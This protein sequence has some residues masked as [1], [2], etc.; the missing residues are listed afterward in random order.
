[1]EN[2]YTSLKF[3]AKVKPIKPINNEFTLVKVYIQSVGKNRNFTDMSK[4]SINKYLPT[5]NYCPV[6]GHIRE[7]TDE[8]GILH[9]Y[10]GGHDSE[11]D[12]DKLEYRDLT[13][14]YGVV[15]ENSFDYEMVNEYD[16]DVEYLVGNAI[17]WT[18]RYSELKECIYSND[19]WFNQS[20]ELSIDQYKPYNEDSN[21]TELL[22]WTYS[23]L[24]LL[25]KADEN[26]TNGHTDK[27]IEHTEPCFI[28]SCV[29][30]IE[31]SKTEFSE[32]MNEMKEKL[33]F[34][35]K[36]HSS[37]TEVDYKNETGG[38]SMTTEFENEVV[39]EEVPET[40]TV[41]EENT[42]EK[43][44]E[45][46]EETTKEEVVEEN[47]ETPQSEESEVKEPIDYSVLY[48]ELKTKYDELNEEYSAYKAEHSFLDSDY[49][50]LKT[51]K[52]T[53][54]KEKREAD[55]AS[56]FAE[57]ENEIGE[58]PEFAELKGKA[59]EFSIDA[60]KK[61]CLCIV[62]LYA[63]ANK[64]PETKDVEQKEIKF[65]IESTAI[66]AEDEPYGGLMKKYLGR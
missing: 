46:I 27:D 59:S 17:L 23:A 13:V 2:K 60:L 40:E 5:L 54:E 9:R 18:G 48:E 44:T 49:A 55:E 34:C 29:K 36:N 21:Y 33:S 20:M 37:T 39:A 32:I 26:S 58:T 42:T 56:V 50:E 43:V 31:F 41:V 15:V 57:Y 4:D 47:E 28:S 64:T 25:G 61:E 11:I 8:D 16:E 22:S 38:N 14:P 52:E 65:S 53:T 19:T 62:G 45:T 10:M 30:P 12:W 7:Y 3:S 6:V 1:M 24:C 51:F 66:D 35:L 63:R